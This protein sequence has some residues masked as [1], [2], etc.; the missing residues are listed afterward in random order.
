[1]RNNKCDLLTDRCYYFT[2]LHFC[3]QKINFLIYE[4]KLF[5]KFHTQKTV[6]LRMSIV[7]L[8]NFSPKSLNDNIKKGTL[9]CETFDHSREEILSS[10]KV[11]QQSKKEE[12]KLKKF[13]FIEAKN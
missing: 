6:S 8:N 9:C 7:K 12:E 11:K 13:D 3:T 1:M 4:L 2:L 5:L 10:H